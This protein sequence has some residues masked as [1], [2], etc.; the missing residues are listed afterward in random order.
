M[1]KVFI[2]NREVNFRNKQEELN[3]EHVIYVNSNSSFE[4]ELVGLIRETP[5]DKIVTLVCDSEE[6]LWNNLVKSCKFIQA[7]GGIVQ[8]ENEY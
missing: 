3:A 7:A 6:E 5:E 1:Y 4:N 2:E 8:R